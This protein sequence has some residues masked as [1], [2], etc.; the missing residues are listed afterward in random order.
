MFDSSIK[1]FNSIVV[2]D[3]IFESFRS[4]KELYEFIDNLD[5]PPDIEA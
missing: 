2:T 5:S 1:K 4:Q 3:E